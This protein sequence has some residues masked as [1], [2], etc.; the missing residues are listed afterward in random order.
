MERTDIDKDPKRISFYTSWKVTAGQELRHL[1][2]DEGDEADE[3]DERNEQERLA[4]QH[5]RSIGPPAGALA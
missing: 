2:K 3:G 1:Q 5:A 4:V